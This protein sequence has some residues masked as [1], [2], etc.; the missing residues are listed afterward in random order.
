MTEKVRQ[1]KFCEFN[2]ENLFINMD[3]YSGEDLGRMSEEAWKK[4]TY[5]QLQDRQKPLFKVLGLAKAILDIDPD[6]VMAVEVGGLESLE[7]FNRYFLEDR[8]EVVCPASNSKKGID[9]GYLVRK[10]LPYDFEVKSNRDLRFEVDYYQGKIES[11]FGRDALE[12]HVY[13]KGTRI[14]ALIAISVH[15]KS[16][17]STSREANGRNSREAEAQ[18]L[19][20][21]Y[22]KIRKE[23]NV[24]VFVSGDFNA[25]LDSKEF[26]SLRVLDLVDLHDVLKT[27]KSEKYTLVHFDYQEMPNPNLL[28]QVLLSPE[29]V[30]KVVHRDSYIYRYK[31]FYDIPDDPPK[32]LKERYAMPS[33]HYPV[34]VT[35]KL[36]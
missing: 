17:I 11:G 1:L 25:S 5:S 14:P 7:L 18:A 6:V 33:D 2:L 16:K 29:L 23:Q 26:A 10:N 19:A 4:L 22:R 12:L 31:S 8:Y 35:F 28:D 21:L 32:T 27:P 3:A 30:D 9:L 20:S 36:G 13:E 34:V 24:P 15:L